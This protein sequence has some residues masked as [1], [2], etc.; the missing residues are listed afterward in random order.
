MSAE[1]GF[2]QIVDFTTRSRGPNTMDLLF[3]SHPSLV[4]QC[5]LLP[6]ISD[7]NY[8]ETTVEITYQKS[9]GYKVYFWKQANEGQYDSVFL[10]DYTIET[11]IETL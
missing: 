3:I 8:H 10:Q 4:Q 11:P 1:C 7:P 9:A 6:E 5:T 2:S